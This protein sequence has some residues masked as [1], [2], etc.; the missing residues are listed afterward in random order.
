[1]IMS[2]SAEPVNTISTNSKDTIC[3][4]PINHIC[5]NGKRP[6]LANPICMR[7]AMHVAMAPVAAHRANNTV[8]PV[9]HLERVIMKMR[10]AKKE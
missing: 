7:A 6:N 8:N 4:L 2:V 3:I 1:M 9:N 5:P 10:Q